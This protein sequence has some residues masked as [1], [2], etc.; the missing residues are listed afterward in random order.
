MINLWSIKLCICFCI[1]TYFNQF[2]NLQKNERPIDFVVVVK[3]LLVTDFY[4]KHFDWMHVIGVIFNQFRLPHNYR[5]FLTVKSAQRIKTM[6]SIYF[7][8]VCV[9]CFLIKINVKLNV[10]NIEAKCNTDN[11]WM[12][13][14]HINSS[15]LIHVTYLFQSYRFC[16]LL[17]LKLRIYMI[18]K[19]SK[20]VCIYLKLKKSRYHWMKTHTFDTICS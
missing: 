20:Y 17:P 13:Y 8:I 15:V 19:I 1:K 4:S 11:S 6:H 3:Y 16:S 12:Q 2:D 14:N 9:H 5:L 10:R 18:L 7:Q